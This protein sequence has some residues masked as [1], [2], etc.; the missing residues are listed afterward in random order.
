MGPAGIRV[1]QRLKDVRQSRGLT[2]NLLATRLSDLGRPIDLSALAKIEKGQRR[3]DVDDLIALARALDVSP[4]WLLFP[5]TATNDR[6]DLTAAF[7]MAGREAWQWAV[8]DQ[9]TD[10]VVVTAPATEVGTQLS[11]RSNFWFLQEEWPE[12][13]DQ[14]VRAENCAHTDPRISCVYSRSALEMMLTFLHHN[15]GSGDEPKD[16]NISAILSD[17]AVVGAIGPVHAL[18][19]KIYQQG[20][21]AVH[22]AGALPPAVG[23]ATVIDLFN[24]MKWFARTYT[25]YPARLPDVESDFN[26]SGI[27]QL[28]TAKNQT[29]SP[30]DN[31]GLHESTDLTNSGR[32]D[33]EQVQILT[34][35]IN[36]GPASERQ[37]SRGDS[38]SRTIFESLLEETGWTVG[39]SLTRDYMLPDSEGSDHRFVDYVLWDEDQS[40][41]ALVEID[42]DNLDPQEAFRQLRMIANDLKPESDRSPSLFYV[43]GSEVLIWDEI[44]SSPRRVKGFFTKEELWR[45]LVTRSRRRNLSQTPIDEGLKLRDHQNRI[46]RDVCNAF[47]MGG[48][49]NALVSMAPGSGKFGTYSAL[50]ELLI[51]AGWVSRVLFLTDRRIFVDQATEALRRYLPNLPISNDLRE[52]NSDARIFVASHHTLT[53]KVGDA[54]EFEHSDYGHAFFDLIVIDELAS[55]GNRAYFRIIDYFDAL[56]VGFT[57]WPTDGIDNTTLELFTAEGG[58]TSI[59][60]FQDAVESGHAVAPE[61]IKVRIT[62]DNEDGDRSVSYLTSED[63]VDSA[64][65]ILLEKGMSASDGRVGKTII[66]AQNAGHAQLI[67]HRFR[68][69]YPDMESNFLLPVTS[70]TTSRHTSEIIQGFREPDGMPRVAVSSGLLDTGIDVPEVVNLVFLKRVNSTGM[71]WRMLAR[72]AQPAPNLLVDGHPKNAFRI[73]DFCDTTNH[74]FNPIRGTA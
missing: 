33:F 5:E 11:K 31:T 6:V 50:V 37:R 28:D 7:S 73:L 30:V 62:S 19:R 54:H 12:L 67:A 55:A 70:R 25:F 27:T 52:S 63:A 60:S 71:F 44:M 36:T 21:A 40:P 66:F 64:L 20:S 9:P 26:F 47:E 13:Y 34:V 17:P 39:P 24:V 58:A 48:R 57:S 10:I 69:N 72:G 41:L 3:V 65:K 32:K 18:A 49:R 38:A 59:Y 56:V 35:D 53:S 4:N 23:L 2:L 42:T 61:V 45:R 29:P 51:R 8:R 1:G 14:A 43:N 74:L 68:I 46:V 15:I 16:A 22:G